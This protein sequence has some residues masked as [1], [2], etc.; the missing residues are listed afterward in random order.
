MPRYRVMA[1]LDTALTGMVL[2]VI[3]AFGLIGVQARPDPDNGITGTVARDMV[4]ATRQNC[5]RTKGRPKGRRIAADL[6]ALTC[7]SVALPG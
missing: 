6:Q 1:G 5:W 2:L 7:Q 4:N 3:A